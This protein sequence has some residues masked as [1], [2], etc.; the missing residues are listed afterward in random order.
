MAVNNQTQGQ[1]QPRRTRKLNKE[2]IKLAS[3][4]LR[5]STR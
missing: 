3:V 4:Y 5:K 2:S 1:Y